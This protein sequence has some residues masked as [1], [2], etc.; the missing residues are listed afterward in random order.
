MLRLWRALVRFGFRLL[1]NEMAFT[2]DLVSRVVSLGEWPCW[3]RAALRYLPDAPGTR[4]LELAF[5]TGSFHADML[6]H[7]LQPVG[8]DL[9]AAMVR[10]ARGKLSRK[11]LPVRLLRGR[12][13]ALPFADASFPAVVSTFPT[14]FIVEPVTLAEVR[15]V[16][17]PGGR[18]VVVI[19]GAFTRRSAATAA[20]D[21]AYRATGQHS[22][23]TPMSEAYAALT[24]HFAQA[25]FDARIAVE[26][27]QRSISVVVVADRQPDPDSSS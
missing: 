6:A 14:D 19:N 23:R 25:G 7:G 1:Y 9:S 22:V 27:C 17:I 20:L 15:R 3:Q 16:L 10:I 12:V 8:I 24:A 4:V 13:Q 26:P 21:V 5:G 2:Y 18:L 11:E